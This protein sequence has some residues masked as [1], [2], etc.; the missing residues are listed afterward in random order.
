[1][2]AFVAYAFAPLVGAAI[3]IAAPFVV[4]GIFAL[5][6][7]LTNHDDNSG[8]S[9]MVE[10]IENNEEQFVQ[11]IVALQNQKVTRE[12]VQYYHVPQEVIDTLRSNM[13]QINA[14]MNKADVRAVE[15]ETKKEKRIQG[16]DIQV[17]GAQKKHM[18][19]AVESAQSDERT[20]KQQKQSLIEQYNKTSDSL[21]KLTD[22]QSKPVSDLND[23]EVA[24]TAKDLGVAISKQ[25]V[26]NKQV[27]EA[28]KAA[29]ASA[30]ALMLEHLSSKS[31]E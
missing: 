9:E 25:D 5:Y 6:N 7:Y 4:D 13:S 11:T 18:Q 15:A 10:E 30:D 27:V 26:V 12:I 31:G 16:R 20:A 14:L 19:K 8:E 1:M 29:K 17:T 3:G 21:S 2:V 23:L 24:K 28:D 22:I